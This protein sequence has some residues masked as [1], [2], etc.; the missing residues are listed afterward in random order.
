MEVSAHY[1]LK[2]PQGS[3]ILDGMRATLRNVA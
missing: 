1:L 2:D 3:L